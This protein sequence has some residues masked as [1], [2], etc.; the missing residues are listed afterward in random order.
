[1]T[2]T[3]LQAVTQVQ[4]QVWSNGDFARIA[5]VMQ[6]V[7]ERLAESADVMPGEK[8]LDVACGSG[9]IAIAAARRFGEVT[10]LDYVP[11][12][13]ETA[14]IR[15]EAEGFPEMEWVEGDAQDLPFEDATFDVV[16][17]SFGVM[18]AP[19][20]PKAA[21]E[22]LRVTKPGGR[23]GLC[24]WTPEGGVG[25]MFRLTTKHAPPPFKIDPPVLWGTEERLNELLGDGVSSM[26]V[27]REFM[28]M[29]GTSAP[30]YL[31]WF[32]TWF[33]PMKTAYER[34][35]EDGFKPLADDFMEAFERR[36]TAGD[37]GLRVPCE[38]LEVI[39]IRA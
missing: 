16:L 19:D 29:K 35:G 5:S 2:D 32:R 21:A 38:Y 36:N 15:A 20:Q 4:K 7:G 26:E 28:N 10:G 25:E 12:L 3:D 1:M 17:S 27:K 8:V 18:F 9:N 6:I 33:G 31:E 30:E 14:R 22:L 37:R 39:A 13:L 11:S 24:N 34:L 23:I